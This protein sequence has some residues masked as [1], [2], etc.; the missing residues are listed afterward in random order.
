MLKLRP[1]RI[2]VG[3]SPSSVVVTTTQ[4]L[5]RQTNQ[6][7][8]GR[9]VPADKMGVFQHL[10]DM[11]SG[12]VTEHG[13]QGSTASIVMSDAL[14]RQW[15]VDPPSNVGS[16]DD[17]RAAAASRF[18][19]LF[20][21]S[22]VQ[23]D[24]RADWQSGRPFVAAALPQVYVQALN[25]TLKACSL[26]ADSICSQTVVALNRWGSRLAGGSWLV[27]YQDGR[28]TILVLDSEAALAGLRQVQCGPQEIDSEPSFTQYLQL[29]AMLMGVPLPPII[30]IPDLITELGWVR[31]ARGTKPQYRVLQKELPKDGLLSSSAALA[32][33]GA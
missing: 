32:L 5:W 26:Q 19:S 14:V 20:G 33:A 31:Y 12:M 15:L 8:A 29:Q 13:L 11:L 28:A 4:G 17:L 10:C 16:L 24:I 30:Q 6:I 27:L 23:W 25:T 2:R 21:E 3:I 18:Q 7:I 9:S 22:P 1:K